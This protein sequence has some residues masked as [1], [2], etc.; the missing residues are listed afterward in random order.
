MRRGLQ[1]ANTSIGYQTYPWLTYSAPIPEGDAGI[2]R[3]IQHMKGLLYGPVGVRSLVVRYA[4]LDAVRGRE[5][6]LSEIES[7][8]RWVKDNIEFRGEYNET[9]QS[10]ECT[11]NLRA[12]DCDDQSLLLA[13]LLASLGYETRFKTISMHGEDDYSHVYAQVRDKRT[14]QWVSLDS[15]VERAYPGWE[16]DDI[17]R[18]ATYGAMPSKPALS[19]E[20]VIG[21]GFLALGFLAL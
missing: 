14:G 8:F 15:T 2:T 1:S 19:A 6:G 17:S 9:L 12:G 10:P 18:A 20:S 21:L 16:P 7:I 3:T 13:A 5:R 11:L 4:A